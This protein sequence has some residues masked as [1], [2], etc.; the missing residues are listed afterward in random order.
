[1]F[2]FQVRL[3]SHLFVAFSL[4]ISLHYHFS[5]AVVTENA[6]FYFGQKKSFKV[7]KSVEF[8]VR[9]DFTFHEGAFVLSPKS[10]GSSSGQCTC[11]RN[12]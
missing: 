12:K 2:P 3:E 4:S 6:G 10:F 1:M 8:S 9:V 11:L 7:F 5:C